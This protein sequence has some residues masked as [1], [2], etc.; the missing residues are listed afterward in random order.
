MYYF[1]TL[2]VSSSGWEIFVA[3]HDYLNL[4]FMKERTLVFLLTLLK[5]L[6][7]E[8]LMFVT[9][10]TV[11]LSYILFTN[12]WQNGQISTCRCR[13]NPTLLVEFHCDNKV[14]QYWDP[15]IKL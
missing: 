8:Y 13:Y 6:N 2:G 15:L 10:I 14:G 1:I 4:G 7:M 9:I 11:S 3:E 12:W 5:D